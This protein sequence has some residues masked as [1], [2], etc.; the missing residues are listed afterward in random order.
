MNDFLMILWSCKSA[1]SRQDYR[2]DVYVCE[3]NTDP[4]VTIYFL[5]P[6]LKYA[7]LIKLS[8]SFIYIA[9]IIYI[10]FT[11]CI[12]IH[13]LYTNIN[14]YYWLWLQLLCFPGNP[15]KSIY[16]HDLTQLT[17]WLISCSHT[18]GSIHMLQVK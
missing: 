5:I 9:Y 16:I 4:R 14:L 1:C 2:R 11:Y 12:Y 3:Y 8:L 7:R 10:Q 15:V 13:Y 6:S 17:M 18:K